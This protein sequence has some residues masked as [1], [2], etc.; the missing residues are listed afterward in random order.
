MFNRKKLKRLILSVLIAL[1]IFSINPEVRGALGKESKLKVYRLVIPGKPW[2]LEIALPPG[3][4]VKGPEVSTAGDRVMIFANDIN[5]QLVVSVYLEK[6][7]SEGDAKTAREYYAKKGEA[8][9]LIKSDIKQYEMND[10]AVGEYMVREFEDRK[11]DQKNMNYYLSHDGCWVDVH[12]S[13]VLYR[14]SDKKYFDG[15]LKNVRIIPIEP[16][17]KD[18]ISATKPCSFALPQHGNLVLQL[19]TSW[20]W[21]IQGNKKDLPPT[22][23]LQPAYGGDAFEL[24]IT[25]MWDPQNKTN[26]NNPESIKKA[27]EYNRT[28]MLPTAVE[29]DVSV[30]EFKG[31]YGQG[32]YF[33]VTDKAPKP[34]EYPYALSAIVGVS[35]FVL[36]CTLLY[37]DKESAAIAAVIK[38][39]EGA[40]QTKSDKNPLP[41]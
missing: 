22:I 14:P 23:F 4:S 37:R 38:M 2:A 5:A 27:I 13:K 28:L 6:A 25:P 8:S 21:R 18:N 15:I 10:A 24:L 16:T 30:R 19:P 7:F 35:D 39:L 33:M 36:H 17:I 9:P 1:A 12:I 26:I 34:G 41:R 31:I 3:F 11:I 20:K 32:Y 40:R 29:Q